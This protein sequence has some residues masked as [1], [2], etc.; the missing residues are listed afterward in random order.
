MTTLKGDIGNGTTKFAMKYT[1]I[2]RAL[3]FIN[4]IWAEN[5]LV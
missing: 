4:I 2:S 1:D 3:Q 5:N